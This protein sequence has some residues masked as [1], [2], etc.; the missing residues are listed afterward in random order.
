VRSSSTPLNLEPTDAVGQRLRACVQLIAPVRG[1]ALDVREHLEGVA[2]EL[3]AL[4]RERVAA[5]A[6]PASAAHWAS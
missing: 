4:D 3:D 2:R 5:V 1:R 6:T